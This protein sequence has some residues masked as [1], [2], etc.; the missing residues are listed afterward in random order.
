ML[1]ETIGIN[2]GKLW[3]FLKESGQASVASLKKNTGLNDKEA[4]LAIGW[5]AREDKLTFEE[6]KNQ[7]LVNLK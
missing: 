6:K 3:E 2:A 4:F 5:L 1:N 7:L